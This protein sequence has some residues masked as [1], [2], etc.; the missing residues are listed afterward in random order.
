MKAT[1]WIVGESKAAT[2]PPL[3][4]GLSPLDRDRASSIAD[5]G[6]ASAATVDADEPAT[7]APPE[8]DLDETPP[9][10]W[11]PPGVK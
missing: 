3:T 8:T 4:E 2:S 7:A 5:E 10:G 11:R 9:L 6:G 1:R